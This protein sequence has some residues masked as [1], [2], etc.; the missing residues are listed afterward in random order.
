MG[1]RIDLRG[2]TGEQKHQHYERV[3]TLYRQGETVKVKEHNT[4]TDCLSLEAWWFAFHHPAG[5]GV[6]K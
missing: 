4:V 2:M 3:H 6:T 5:K 1:N